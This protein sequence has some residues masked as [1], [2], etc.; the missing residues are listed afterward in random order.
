[1]R[2][3]KYFGMQFL[4]LRLFLLLL[5]C[6]ASVMVIVA[7]SGISDPGSSSS[8]VFSVHFCTNAIGKGMNSVPFPPQLWLK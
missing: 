5:G 8:I 3:R 4:T 7:E 1:M 6:V 2:M